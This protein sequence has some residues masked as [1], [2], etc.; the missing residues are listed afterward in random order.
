M[1][2]VLQATLQKLNLMQRESEGWFSGQ[3]KGKTELEC[4]QREYLNHCFGQTTCR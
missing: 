1:I 4:R 3:K 2:H